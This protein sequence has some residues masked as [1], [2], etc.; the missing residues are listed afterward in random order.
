MRSAN[1]NVA[2]GR[3]EAEVDDQLKWIKDHYTRYVGAERA[4][5]QLSGV[6]GMPGCGTPEQIVEK[7]TALKKAG[8]TYGIFNFSN[9]A[10][11]SGSIELFEEEVIPALV[12]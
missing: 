4:E 6:R 7:L 2:I 12:D 8:M 11:D 3:T 5:A 10:Y 9:L 1:Y